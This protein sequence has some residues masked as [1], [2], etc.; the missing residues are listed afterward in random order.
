MNQVAENVLVKQA[1]DI[2]I[3]SL[4]EIGPNRFAEVYANEGLRDESGGQE[5]TRI[6]TMGHCVLTVPA[7]M[8]LRVR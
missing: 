8:P 6:E 7:R 4:I 5:M 2:P 1:A 3:G